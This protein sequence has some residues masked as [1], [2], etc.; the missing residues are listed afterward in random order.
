MDAPADQPD[1]SERSASATPRAESDSAASDPA[2]AQDA[3]A[4]SCAGSEG[5][6]PG[7]ADR[8]AH[9][10]GEPRL[11]AL[12]WTIFLLIASMGAFAAAAIQGGFTVDAYRPAARHLLL[13]VAVGLTVLWPMVR[14]SQPPPARVAWSVVRDLIVLLGPAQAV[15]WPQAWLA[16]WPTRVVVAVSL[17]MIGWTTLIGAVLC[18]VQAA[19]SCTPGGRSHA[20]TPL[21]AMALCLVIVLAGPSIL[22]VAT[23]LGVPPA[24]SAWWVVSPI[25][26]VVELTRG[27]F[28]TPR[29]A[30]VGPGHWVVISLVLLLAAGAW[31]VVV[32]RGPHGPG[33]IH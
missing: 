5:P 19:R 22:A 3:Q 24:G 14:L 1:P 27:G 15:V 30:G 33:R 18:H 4:A 6:K 7:I 32:R 17:L 13:V 8:W 9:R 31:A 25:T 28:W 29:G 10:R 12:V 26:G 20:P 16:H 2:T 21:G 11:F 23:C